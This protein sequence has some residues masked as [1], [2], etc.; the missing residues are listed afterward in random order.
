MHVYDVNADGLADVVA[1]SAHSK[2]VWWYEQKRGPAGPQFTQRVI[3]DSFSQSHSMQMADLDGDGI[4]DFITGKRY[5]AHGPN[6]DIEP[7]HP[8]VLYWYRLIRKDGKVEWERNLIDSDSGVG[9][10]FEA[11]DVNGDGLIDLAISNKKGTYY[12]EQQK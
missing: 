1:S 9:V 8:A 10:Q 11:T 5:W 12:F 7:N 6:G 2:G 4:M 3:D